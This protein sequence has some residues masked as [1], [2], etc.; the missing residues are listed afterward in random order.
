MSPRKASPKKTAP[1][2]TSPSQLAVLLA[3]IVLGSSATVGRAQPAPDAAFKVGVLNRP[4]LPGEPYDWRGAG[5]HALSEVIWYP[6]DAAAEPK[7]QLIPPVGPALFE[8]APAAPN[9]K[10][11]PNPDKF[12]LIVFSHGTGGTAQSNAWFATAMAA[13]G[14][15]VAGVNHPGNTAIGPYTVQ[16]FTLWWKRA[17]DL[18]VVLDDMLADPQFGPRIDRTRIAAAGYSLGGYTV[19]EL[20]G[21]ITAMARFMAACKTAKEP[22]S[23]QG[24]P[25][26]PDIVAQAQALAKADPAFAKALATSNKSY[27]DPRIR[28]IFAM[29][30][31]V[32]TAVTPQSLGAITIPASIVD[33]VADSITPIEGNAKYYAA[34]IPRMELTI[35]PGNVDHY[36]FLDVCT[37]E[38][39]ATRPQLCV[40]KSGVDRQALHD[41]TVDIAAKFF[42]GQLRGQ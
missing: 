12:P 27:R 37:D 9:A 25:E 35:F 8:A 26:F 28:A 1:K 29:A 7:P 17:K 32:G 21:G 19:I 14:Y 34:K 36:T 39:R 2:K 13:R 38:G 41:A 24:P 15:I 16:G 10:L 11:A 30:P 42:A 22:G 31:A 6:A 18:S 4:L 3:L 33:G 40:D 20:A 23:C 5:S